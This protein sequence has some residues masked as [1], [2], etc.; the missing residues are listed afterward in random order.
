MK[1]GYSLLLFSVLLAA[2]A[3]LPALAQETVAEKE[4]WAD[5]PEREVDRPVLPVKDGFRLELDVRSLS[6]DQA[7]DEDGEA[8]DLDDAY[9]LLSAEIS[10]E[11]GVARSFSVYGGLP[12]LLVEFNDTRGGGIGDAFIGC[13][14]QPVA[15]PRGSVA[16][17][18]HL[19]LPSGDPDYHYT[20]EDGERVLD[21][22]RT[23]D[24]GVNYYPIIEGR[25][26]A[27]PAS[28]RA[29]AYYEITGEGDVVYDKPF[30]REEDVAVDPGDGYGGTAA[31]YMQA[32]S[33]L[34]FYGGVRHQQRGETEVDIDGEDLEDDY[35]LTEAMGGALF[36]VNDELDISVHGGVPIAG[37][38]TPLGLSFNLGIIS[39]F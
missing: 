2:L 14:Y 12:Y 10:I 34:V 24:P 28:F 9:Q 4:P 7:L 31:V 20:I 32:A 37:K 33:W 19:S 39:R 13:A 16:I 30:S 35:Y 26:N 38:N 1:K 29:S 25:L 15:N 18:A 23:G 36:Q 27:G 8:V 17:G 22:V 21:N 11:Y 3:G 6:T 5:Y